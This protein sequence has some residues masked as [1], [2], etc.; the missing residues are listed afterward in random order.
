[1]TGPSEERARLGFVDGCVR[2]YGAATNF[3]AKIYEREAGVAMPVLSGP[4]KQRYREALRIYGD[5]IRGTAGRTTQGEL[6]VAAAADPVFADLLSDSLRVTP[7]KPLHDIDDISPSIF[8]NAIYAEAEARTSAGEIVDVELD[9]FLRGTVARATEGIGWKR[10]LNV[11]VNRHFPRMLH[12]L[13][14]VEEETSD[15]RGGGLKLM[16]RGGGGRVAAEPD[17]PADLKV[18]LDPSLL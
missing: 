13:R 7:D 8:K 14:E 1:M 11:G 12:W 17:G 18:R 10:R 6:K 5:L 4:P 2:T 15:G 9:A 16:N 3:I